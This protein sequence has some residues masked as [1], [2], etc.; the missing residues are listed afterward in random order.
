MSHLALM[1]MVYHD[2]EFPLLF[3]LSNTLAR[4]H[5]HC[6]VQEFTGLGDKVYIPT[7]M[8]KNLSLNEGDRVQVESRSL[9][10]AKYVKFEP[11]SVDFLD[12]TNP[13]VVLE[14][15]L[16]DFSC[17]TLDDVIAIHYNNKVY[18]M[19]VIELQPSDAVNI[20]SCDLEVDF[21]APVGYVEP[22]EPMDVSSDDDDERER[23]AF[24]SFK[25]AGQ[26][27][28]GKTKNLEM[29]KEE[30]KKRLP[31]KRRGIPDYDYEPGFLTF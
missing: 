31:P 22:E 6:G 3:K 23:G 2:M 14:K 17:L 8:M 29:S 15:T 18:E 7:W 4:R 24:Y 12:I 5:T 20:I 30:L 26:R 10:V 16:R 27:L 25:G 21:T 11:Q 13:R 1:E 19:R 9:P 28:N